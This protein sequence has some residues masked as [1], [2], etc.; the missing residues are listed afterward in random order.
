VVLKYNL[1]MDFYRDITIF[2]LQFTVNSVWL[3]VKVFKGEENYCLNEAKIELKL[4]GN[5]NLN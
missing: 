3:T 2:L 4:R 5:Q 1:K